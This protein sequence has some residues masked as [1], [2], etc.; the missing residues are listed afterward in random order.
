MRIR[1]CQGGQHEHW[2]RSSARDRCWNSTAIRFVS[3]NGCHAS[4]RPWMAAA[5]WLHIIVIVDLLHGA[6]LI[7]QAAEEC[8][9]EALRASLHP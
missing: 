2:T 9:E 6:D 8:A 1:Q 3:G 7:C 4:A 5:G